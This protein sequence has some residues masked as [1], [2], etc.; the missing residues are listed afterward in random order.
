MNYNKMRDSIMIPNYQNKDTEMPDKIKLV[1]LVPAYN[2]EEL[3]GQTI[4]QIPRKILGVSK[5]EVLVVDDGSTDKTVDIALNAGIDKIVSHNQNLGVGASFMTGVRNAISMNADILVT[6]DAD[7]QF[8]S[9]Q[10]PEL[11]L[12]IMKKQLDVVIGSRFLRK[13]PSMPKIKMIGN[14][15]FAKIV[16][17][18][19]SQKLSDTQTGFRAY[20]KEILLLVSVVNEFTYTQEVLIDLKFKGARIGEIPVDVKYDDKRKSRVVKNIFNYSVNAL[21]IILKSF[22]THRPLMA[23]GLLGIFLCGSGVLGKVLR[24]YDIFHVSSDLLNGLIILGIVSFMLGLFA[25]VVFKR[26]IFTEIELKRNFN[27]QY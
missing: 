24:F 25:N 8:N 1:I 4:M 26:Q 2:E 18:V 15:I 27:I 17:L 19:I 6:L 3:I 5:V 10:I 16:S 21:S 20:S 22:I 14:K 9:K 13:T 12:P 23:F 11:I 7:S